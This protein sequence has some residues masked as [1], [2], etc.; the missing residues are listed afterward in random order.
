MVCADSS[1]ICERALLLISTV[2]VGCGSP[3]VES[4]PG[5]TTRL[6]KSQLNLSQDNVVPHE[7]SGIDPT[8]PVAEV[9]ASSVLN[10]PGE[11]E[12]GNYHVVK[13][14]ETLTMIARKFNVPMKQ[15]LDANG[16]NSDDP[17]FPEQMIYIPSSR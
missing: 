13:R 3:L 10:L 16:L 17:I 1:H 7:Q 11:L 2:L 9:P 14:G 12:S 8:R 4:G 6:P 15:L 5:P